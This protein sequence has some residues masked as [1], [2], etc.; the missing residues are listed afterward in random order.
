MAVRGLL[1]ILA[2]AVVVWLVV[3]ALGAHAEQ[4]LTALA[5]G[6]GAPP[7]P[8]QWRRAHALE[9]SAGRANP[10]A[11]RL[12]LY[13]GVLDLRAHDPAAAARTFAAVARHQPADL[14]AWA[15]AA[16][17]AQQAGDDRLAHTAQAHARALAPA[18]PPPPP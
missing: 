15:L 10:D 7:T 4:Q 1:V 12:K 13:D 2:A 3:S 18:V 8:A 6:S 14:E 9:R 16:R 17:A 5:F 11:Q